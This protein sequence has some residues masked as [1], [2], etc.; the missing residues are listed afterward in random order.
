MVNDFPET[1]YAR[2]GDV[3]L[4]YQVVGEQGPDLLFMPTAIFPIDLLGV[5]SSDAVPI[6]GGPAMQSWTDG[7]AAVLDAVGSESAT[8]PAMSESALP[9]MLLSPDPHPPARSWSPSSWAVW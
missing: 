9:D 6:N 3:H 7:L 1:R 4:A 5:G 2:D 8:V